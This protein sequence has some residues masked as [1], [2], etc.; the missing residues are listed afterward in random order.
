MYLYLEKCIEYVSTLSQNLT[1][2]WTSD[3]YSQS[4]S[5]Q[6]LLFPDGI[7]YD[8]KNEE[9]LTS[10]INSLFLPIPYLSK[11]LEETKKRNNNKD[12]ID[13]ALVRHTGFEPVTPTLS[14]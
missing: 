9:F 4:E 3:N 1:D 13:S 6:Q 2:T 10:R 11:G 14:R 12:A 7:C 8:F 5:V